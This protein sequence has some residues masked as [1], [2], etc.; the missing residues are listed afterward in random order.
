MTYCCC[1]AVISLHNVPVCIKNLNVYCSV[2][3]IISL[4]ICVCVCV[5]VWCVC[6]CGVCVCVCELSH[7][8]G[9]IKRH[10]SSRAPG[11]VHRHLILFW[12]DETGPYDGSIF[13]PEESYRVC[14][15]VSLSVVKRNSNSGYLQWIVRRGQTKRKKKSVKTATDYK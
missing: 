6:V 14:V 10:Y 15:C 7:P 2:S 3:E 4:Y 11:H 9:L 12:C 1:T 8:D 13:C 5:C